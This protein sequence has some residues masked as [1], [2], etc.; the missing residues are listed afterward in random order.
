M[1]SRTPKVLHEVAGR[2][3]LAHV[4]HVAHTVHP[5]RLVVVVGHGRERVAEHLAVVDPDAVTV[6]QEEQNGTGHAM[7][8]A[9]SALEGV[10][11]TVVV[12][13]GDSPLVTTATLHGLCDE[14][15]GAMRAA[16]VV[17]AIRRG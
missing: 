16:T 2:S 17:A 7:R 13:S 9:L 11:G 8:V 1:H 12:L 5:E 14:H 6:V 10:D 15:D 3:L 4:V